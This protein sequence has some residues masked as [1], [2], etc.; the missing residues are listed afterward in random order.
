MQRQ[1]GQSKVKAGTRLLIVDDDPFYR[2]MAASSLQAAGYEVF[3]AE[4]GV[5]GLELLRSMPLD[6]AVVDLTM[7]GMDGFEVIRRTRSEGHNPSLPMIVITGQD[8]VS[9]VEQAFEVGATSFVAKPINWPLFVNHVH[10]VGRAARAETDLRD[11]IRTAEFLSNLKSKVLS[12]LVSESQQPLRTAQGMAE[13]LRK[14]VYGPLGQRIYQDYAQDLHR[15]LE[16]LSAT[17]LKMMNAG[18]ALASELLLQEEVIPLGEIV[19]EAIDGLR[20][21]ADRRAVEIEA[22]IAIPTE[23]LLR[24]DRSLINQALKMMLDSAISYAPRRSSITVDARLDVSG[25]FTFTVSDDGPSLPES[26]IREILATAPVRPADGNAMA[27]A[28]NTGLTISRVLVE[29]HQGR[30]AIN[31]TS[32]EGTIVRLLI[33][34]ERLALVSERKPVDLAREAVPAHA[35]A[36]ADSQSNHPPALRMS[37]GPGPKLFG[38]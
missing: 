33:P 26:T 8:D 12:V 37:G 13:L 7:P 22:R 27:A 25:A 9:S 14:E 15:S 28:R 21:K 2:D 29:A 19:R 36:L 34:S 38:R 30:I 10:F 17:Q 31:S 6:M 23:K 35:A 16:Q 3:Q 32:G 1:M 20:E 11:A 24:C 18:R 5:Q 4:D